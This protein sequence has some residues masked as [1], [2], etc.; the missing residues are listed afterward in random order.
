[1][2]IRLARRRV[3]RGEKHKIHTWVGRSSDAS[4][5]AKS[6]VVVLSPIW[7]ETKQKLSFKRGNRMSKSFLNFRRS[8]LD[9]G[10]L[11]LS[12]PICDFPSLL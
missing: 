5:D 2:A 3:R 11:L 10:D 12:L 6:D 7:T 8:R 9:N 1:M 4:A